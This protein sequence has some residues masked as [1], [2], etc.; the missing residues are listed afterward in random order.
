M[1]NKIFILIIVILLIIVAGSAYYYFYQFKP[2]QIDKKPQTNTEIPAE[3]QEK[4]QE[5]IQQTQQQ[6]PKSILDY[7]NI[8]PTDYIGEAIDME[9]D[10]VYYERSKFIEILDEKNYYMRISAK[11]ANLERGGGASYTDFTLF[12]GKNSPD[13][14]VIA[15]TSCV[16]IGCLIN[17]LYFLQYQNEKWIDVQDS[18]FPK[19]DEDFIKEKSENAVM[20]KFGNLGDDPESVPVTLFVLPRYGATIL[21]KEEKTDTIIYKLQ[22]NGKSF[23]AHKQ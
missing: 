6:V 15:N 13:T 23:D 10:G 1:K 5:Q 2:A 12:L 7:Y 9:I 20:N 16:S 4:E 11:P 17:D 19:L 8:I 21:L 3:Q 18:V 22:W 14:L